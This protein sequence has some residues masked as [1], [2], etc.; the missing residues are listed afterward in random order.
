MT[1]PGTAPSDV[2]FEDLHVGEL[3][4]EGA[5]GRV[6]QMPLEPH[7]VLKAF[8]RPASREH[9]EE[10]VA[11]P[12]VLPADQARVVSAASA[13]PCSVV[14]DRCGAAVGLL[15][16]RAPRRFALRHRDGTSRL[17]S[18]SYLTAD[19][20]HRRAAYGLDLPAPAGAE[21]VALAYAL[22]R[23]LAVFEAADPAVAH[24]DLSTK[25]VLWSLQRVPEIFVIDCD[26]SERYPS[27][28]DP[29]G[30]LSRRRPMTPNWNDP[31]VG[32]GENPTPASDRYSMALVFLRVLGA[33][34]FPIQAR[35]REGG[36]VRVEVAVPAL[37]A[38]GRSAAVWDLCARGLG[39]ADP[40]GRPRAAAW[41]AALESL[42]HDMGAAALSQAVRQA[43]GG[44]APA[45]PPTPPGAGPGDVE[46]V[47]VPATGRPDR[48]WARVNPAHR[49]GSGLVAPGQ[50]AGAAAGGFRSYPG[51]AAGGFRSYPG[52]GAPPASQRGGE[53]SVAVWPELA[54][55]IGRA[56]RWWL[57]I[58]RD[59]LKSLPTAGRRAAG[60]RLLAWCALVDLAA[61][62]VGGFVLA[63][64]IAPILGL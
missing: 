34:N 42:L 17:A 36:T 49:G 45:S 20:G 50:F 54:A 25:N 2:S 11:W 8:R 19:P 26:S 35:Q 44:W 10:L 27:G 38:L 3:L 63:I 29:V 46:I 23:L 22:A 52:A 21:R 6:Y 9:L 47:P 40:A 43:Q 53:V 39:T 24:G 14:T 30:Q 28:G 7:L 31:A 48:A 5:E 41:V 59:V 12:S 32:R 18:L 51:A 37:P 55:G 56:A 58:H 57:G 61:A 33:A 62:V 4:A 16:P 1:G 60:F 13:W 15:M 64:V